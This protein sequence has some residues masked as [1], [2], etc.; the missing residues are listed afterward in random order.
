MVFSLFGRKDRPDARRG[1]SVPSDRI[2]DSLFKGPPT[3][4]TAEAQRELARRTAEKID[5]IESE[6]IDAPLGATTTQAPST[7][8]TQVDASASP[9]RA[10]PE[11]LSPLEFDA[12]LPLGPLPTSGIQIGDSV[13]P[14]PLEEAAILYANGQASAAVATLRAFVA[15]SGRDAQALQAWRMLFD[16]LQSS[17][18]RAEFDQVALEFAARFEKSPPAWQQ[19]GPAVAPPRRR[20]SGA[21]VVAF[22]DTLDASVRGRLEAALRLGAARRAVGFDFAAVRSVDADGGALVVAGVGAFAKAGWELTLSGVD[23]LAAAA[24]AAIESG[25]RDPGDGA[26]QLALLALR[27]QGAHERFDERAIDFCVTYEISP[28]SW[29]PLPEWIQVLGKE[30]APV[31]DPGPMPEVALAMG[32]ETGFYLRGEIAGRMTA[33]LAALQ[34]WAGGRSA[35]RI[36]CRQLRRLD[37]VAAGELL[38]EVVALS[39]AGRQ[40][41]FVE[42]GAMVESLMMVMGLHELAEIRRRRI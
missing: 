2:P 25:R 7:T 13:L 10:P 31:N 37:F 30:E 18:M 42:P 8:Q 36:D 6:M 1:R 21:A 26:W 40:V 28:P 9:Q 23:A 41:I 39:A 22:P 3:V 20:P 11:E 5:R 27:L 34:A 12:G 16:A 35:L 4:Q 33:E 29:E 38:N 32:D 17:G 14:P 19:E 15:E 24:D